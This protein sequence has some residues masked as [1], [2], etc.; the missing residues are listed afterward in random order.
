M[1]SAPPFFVFREDLCYNVT[2]SD[3]SKRKK[4]G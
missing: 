3:E 2:T 4:E 1:F